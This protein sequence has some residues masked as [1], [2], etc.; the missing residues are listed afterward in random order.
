VRRENEGAVNLRV[1]Q[2]LDNLCDP[3][4]ANVLLD[5]ISAEYRAAVK[6]ATSAAA[7][8][9]ESQATDHVRELERESDRRKREI[10]QLKGTIARLRKELKT[11][12]PGRVSNYEIPE[13][14]A[15]LWQCGKR[16]Y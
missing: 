12:R 7:K 11:L 10:T 13:Q 15:D 5:L 8:I 16:L 9:V 4:T 2:S 6:G 14:D 3:A 1:K